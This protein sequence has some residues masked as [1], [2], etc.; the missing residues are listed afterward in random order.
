MGLLHEQ[1]NTLSD[2]SS[3]ITS[4]RFFDRIQAVLAQADIRING[5]RPWDL[6]VHNAKLFTRLLR[7]G[8]LGFAE[9]Y[10]EG[11]WDCPQVDQLL[12]R[13]LKAELSTKLGGINRLRLALSAIKYT[14]LNH[15]TEQRAHIV[16][17]VHY[18]IGND[19]YNRM[20]DPTMSYSCGYWQQ[21]TDL[22]SAQIDK[23][24][25]ICRKL[26]LK[27]G[28][29][30][31]DIGCGWGGLAEFAARNYGVSVVGVTISKEQKRLA[32]ERVAGL[33]VTIKLQDYRSLNGTFDRIA[34]V[35]MFE[36]VGAKNYPTFF[37]TA[38]RLLKTD[39]LFLLHT[40]GEEQTSHRPEPFIDKYIF[41]NGNVASRKH[42]QDATL[43]H[44]RLEDW[45][46]FGQD[47]DLTLMAW[48]ENFQRAWPELDANYS[49][50]FYRMWLYYL[51]GCAAFFRSRRGQLW[52][53]VLA[54][55]QRTASYRCPR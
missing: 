36:H 49:Q 14:L 17:E 46:N 42:L 43:G 9:A 38:K 51:Y 26:E 6:Q 53:L 18:D 54:H 2:A 37:H 8:A 25:L 24:D 50:R 19:L 47:Y 55:P 40:I 13:M 1:F 44:F 32:D 12:T 22:N 52:Q 21:A 3:A 27:P 34:S 4:S 39:G 48:A 33:P 41:P 11:W 5:N 23:L 29:R 35:G 7:H 16:G 45:H 20:L 28:M 15:Q 31:L 30:L 10:M